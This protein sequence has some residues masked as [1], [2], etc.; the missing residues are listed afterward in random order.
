MAMQYFPEAI[1]LLKEAHFEGFQTSVKSDRM[2]NDNSTSYNSKWFLKIKKTIYN[3][4]TSLPA[5]QKKLYGFEICS[6]HCPFIKSFILLNQ[7][8]ID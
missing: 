2:V 3:I 5:K 6:T 7:N 4:Y 1:L 8:I